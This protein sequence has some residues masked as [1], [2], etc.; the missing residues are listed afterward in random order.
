V[1]TRPTTQR[2]E[3]ESPPT[4]TPAAPRPDAQAHPN[5]IACWSAK[6]GAGTTVIAAALSL[7]LARQSPAVLVDMAGDAPAVLGLPEPDGPGLAGWLRS[8][9]SNSLTDAAAGPGLSLISRGDGPLRA[10]RADQLAAALAR[11]ARPVV[12]DC[13]TAPEGAAG[14]LAERAER[15]ILVTR[16][17]YLALRRFVSVPVARPTGVVVVCEPGR[18][19]TGHDV[20]AAVGAPMLAEISLDPAVARAVDAGLLATRLPASLTAS[21]ATVLEA[22]GTPERGARPARRGLAAL[23]QPDP[24]E[25]SA[26]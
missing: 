19:L 1:T 17:C 21:A 22:I 4:G 12:I 20:A 24:P 18:F 10:D 14:V 9:S 23:A 13:G 26:W 6:G 15:S 8:E 11:S 7:R 3:T 16:P 5:V 25:V 2:H